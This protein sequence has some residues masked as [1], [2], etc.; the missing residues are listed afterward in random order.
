VIVTDDWCEAKWDDF[1]VATRLRAADRAG[2]DDL[3]SKATREWAELSKSD[4]DRLH[5]ELGHI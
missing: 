4:R 1:D 2:L 3:Q 5:D